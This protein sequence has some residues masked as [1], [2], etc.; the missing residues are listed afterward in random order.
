MIY[1]ASKAKHG[2]IWRALRASG[3]PISATWIDWQGNEAGRLSWVV[4]P[5]ARISTL[6]LSVK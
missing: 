5:M 3:L 2:W 1:C 6:A 4:A